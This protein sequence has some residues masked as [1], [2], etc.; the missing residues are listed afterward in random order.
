MSAPTPAIAG[1]RYALPAAS[2]TVRE[3]GLEGRLESDAGLLERF[4]FG[5]V[6]IAIEESPYDLAR[7]AAA[8][9]LEE[10]C[11]DPATIGLLIYGGTPGPVAFEPA[12]ADWDAATALRTTGR[13]K[14]PATRL[15]HELGLDAAAALG[16]D[17]LACTTMFSA[18]RIAHALIL[19]DGIERALCVVGECFPADAGREAIFNCTSDAGCAVLIERSGARNRL[20]TSAHV[21]KGY[22]WDCDARRN[23][24]IASYF[25]TAAHV[26]EQVLARAGWRPEDVDWV[27]PHNVSLR[28][29]EILLGLLR[30]PRARLFSCNIARHGHTLAGDNFINLADALSDGSVRPGQRLLLF[31]YGYGG[32]WTALA[33]E[34]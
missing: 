7:T 9:L 17:Q 5:Q 32:H 18:I 22:Y 25:P 20:V 28:S 2:R 13:F 12:A 31:S 27:I 21:T 29:W 14:Y 1:I 11:V 6:H 30:L 34:A 4:G 15:Q 16:L 24:I 3:L 10:R 19:T 26:V 23:E 33:V 8:A